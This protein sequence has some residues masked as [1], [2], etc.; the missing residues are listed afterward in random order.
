MKFDSGNVKVSFG[1]CGCNGQWDDIVGFLTCLH[2]GEGSFHVNEG[3][4]GD[5]GGG[6]CKESSIGNTG[7]RH[8]KRNVGEGSGGG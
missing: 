8:F 4:V 3:S 2:L 6:D 5:A 1:A 7:N